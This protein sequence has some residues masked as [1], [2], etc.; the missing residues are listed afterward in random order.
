M[1]TTII[2]KTNI[3]FF[4]SGGVGGAERVTLTIAKLLDKNKFN[5]KIII[6]DFPNCPLSKFIPNDIPVIYLSE[7]HLR[8]RCLIK[9]KNIIK[10]N[11]ADYSFSSMTFVNILLLVCCKL[12]TT[13]VKPIIRGQIN[14]HYWTK[15]TGKMKIKGWIVEKINRI[16]YPI[17][18]KVVAQTPVMRDGII[19]YFGVKPYK[20]ICLYNPIDKLNIEEKIK[21]KNPYSTKSCCFKYVAVGRCQP[22]KGF[23]LL[24]KAMEKVITYNPNSH[25]YIVG[26]ITNDTYCKQLFKL[27]KENGLWNNIHFVGFQS[28]PYKY[29]KYSDCFILSSRDEGLPNVLIEATYLHKQSIAYTC[30]PI[31]KEIVQNEVNGLLVEPENVEKLAEAMIKIQSLNL[32]VASNYRP[33]DDKDFDRLFE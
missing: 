30:I 24:I 26:A 5:V 25:V 12:F 7:K 3:L 1:F 13:N 29:I 6:T 15:H 8:F 18:Y 16:L 4:V 10:K 19:K 23:D 21:E 22:Q 9:M 11:K 31:I 33:S 28:N 2:M 14:P 20:C 27:V 32:N 17:A